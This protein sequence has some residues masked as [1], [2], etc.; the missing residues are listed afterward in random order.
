MQFV[1]REKQAKSTEMLLKDTWKG[2]TDSLGQFLQTS[3][4]FDKLDFGL[5]NALLNNL[6]NLDIKPIDRKI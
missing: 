2:M 5:Q 1:S 6:D 3:D 4:S